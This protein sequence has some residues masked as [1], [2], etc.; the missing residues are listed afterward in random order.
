MVLGSPLLINSESVVSSTN[1]CC[2]VV[3]AIVIV[4]V[5]PPLHL[6]TSKVMVIVWRLRANI[7]STVLYIA[8]VLPLH[9]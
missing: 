3:V 8:N 6:T 2:C 7:I 9:G 4:T 5:P 1:L